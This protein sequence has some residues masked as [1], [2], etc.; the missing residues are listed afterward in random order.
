MG[1]RALLKEFYIL[2]ELLNQTEKKPDSHVRYPNVLVFERTPSPPPPPKKKYRRREKNLLWVGML[3]DIENNICFPVPILLPPPH[4]P[5]PPNFVI[6]LMEI[7][8][9]MWVWVV[10]VRWWAGS[11]LCRPIAGFVVFCRQTVLTRHW[12]CCVL[13]PKCVTELVVAPL[14]SALNMF[15]TNLRIWQFYIPVMC[16]F[17]V[18]GYSSSFIF[19]YYFF[20]T[21]QWFCCTYILWL[22]CVLAHRLFM[23]CSPDLPSPVSS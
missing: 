8:M 10:M 15:L 20:K 3:P 19:Y 18:V 4:P 13:L 7:L 9:T 16:D 2:N 11:E 14:S 17:V 12:L 21:N 1:S 5:F 6:I 23:F 22:Q